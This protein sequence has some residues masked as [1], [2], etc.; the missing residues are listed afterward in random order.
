MKVEVSTGVRLTETSTFA[1]SP[2]GLRLAFVGSGAD[3]VVRLWVRSLDASDARPLA[4]TEVA[5][6]G[7]VPPMF[8]S[9]DSRFRRFRR[10]R[11]D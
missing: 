2:D 5:L 3:G 1:I 10:R 11:I 4:G 6:G 8:W 9:P 7:K